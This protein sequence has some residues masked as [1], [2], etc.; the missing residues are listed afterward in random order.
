LVTIALVEISFRLARRR[1]QLFGEERGAAGNLAVLAETSGFFS[2]ALSMS[3]SLEMAL[4]RL[5]VPADWTTLI[6]I[7]E[8]DRSR[9]AVVAAHGPLASI[10]TGRE[11]SETSVP[12]QIWYTVTQQRQRLNFDDLKMAAPDQYNKMIAIVPELA[13]VQSAILYPLLSHDLS[14]GYLGLVGPSP[15]SLSESTGQT[16]EILSRLIAAN[17][18]AG[19]FAEQT[20][21]KGGCIEAILETLPMPA[22][23]TDKD[24][25]V[26]YTNQVLAE[27]LKTEAS[28]F[29]GRRSADILPDYLDVQMTTVGED[30]SILRPEYFGYVDIDGRPYQV[31]T[32][33]LLDSK[34]NIESVVYVLTVAAATPV[35]EVSG[36]QEITSHLIDRVGG[37]STASVSAPEILSGLLKDIIELT[38]A[39]A[40][41]VYIAPSKPGAPTGFTSHG[42]GST[43]GAM[44][45]RDWSQVLAPNDT[46][47]LMIDDLETMPHLP[48]GQLLAS[49]WRAIT[50]IPICKHA[51]LIGHIGL[52]GQAPSSIVAPLQELKRVGFIASIV[53]NEALGRDAGTTDTIEQALAELCD[54]VYQSASLSDAL[55]V[56]VEVVQEIVASP[57]STVSILL[58]D[59][60][61]SVFYEAYTS[62]PEAGSLAGREIVV[63][64]I[65]APL[66]NLL[67]ADGALVTSRFSPEV[68]A[69]GEAFSPLHMIRPWIAAPVIWQDKPIAII[70]SLDIADLSQ[71]Q[72]DGI[73]RLIPKI[74]PVIGIYQQSFSQPTAGLDAGK[75][76]VLYIVSH[77]LRTPLASL[78][79]ANELLNEMS[80]EGE[81][82]EYQR[83]LLENASRSIARLERLVS[84]LADVSSLEN[85]TLRL[86]LEKSTVQDLVAEAVGLMVPL[87][88]TKEQ[89]LEI[90]LPD[91]LPDITVDRH[92]FGQILGNLLSNAHKYGKHAGRLELRV[93]QDRNKGIVFQVSDDGPGITLADQ[94]RVFEPFHTDQKEMAR[95]AISGG[96]GLMIA[97]SLV[98][99]HGGKIWLS[100]EPGQGTTFYF[101]IPIFDAAPLAN[102]Q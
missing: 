89:T 81:E 6:A 2:S 48:S 82:S 99:R 73:A 41:W 79:A 62:G 71:A 84:D 96:L 1:R 26:T 5:P 20:D 50:I 80:R 49:G 30:E 67:S 83:R 12:P 97:K 95:R 60:N 88:V 32:S 61:R 13:T 54:K 40:G 90:D 17:V 16:L 27:L 66:T 18:G 33:G 55:K 70:T 92:R 29:I 102:D 78:K 14:I 9:F 35:E 7:L 72:L 25:I 74:A 10:L 19:H 76:E 93:W 31:H 42:L 59:E 56:T 101:S 68:A 37:K 21:S 22:F 23:V 11:L 36:C 47:P 91:H 63:N 64:R 39:G 86:N 28:S 46:N 75:R 4:E 58:A 53:A 98:E 57:T 44:M 43:I 77:E 87:I 51:G 15:I 65:P 100:S 45:G 8:G 69:S 52:A 38:K 24:S 3:K 34:S 94:Q 85:D